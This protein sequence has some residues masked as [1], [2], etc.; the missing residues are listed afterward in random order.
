LSEEINANAVLQNIRSE[1]PNAKFGDD[2]SL[3]QINFP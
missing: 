2:V 1:A 3:L